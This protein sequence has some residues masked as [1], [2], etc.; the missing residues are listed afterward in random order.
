MKL[1][2]SYSKGEC[3]GERFLR[4]KSVYKDEETTCRGEICA[5]NSQC[6]DCEDFIFEVVT[7]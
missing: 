2:A 5:R 4:R 3:E 1:K 7:P 6:L